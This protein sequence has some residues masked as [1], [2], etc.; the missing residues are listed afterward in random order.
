MN[1]RSTKSRYPRSVR[2]PFCHSLIANSG[3]CPEESNDPSYP[4]VVIVHRCRSHS[5]ANLYK[6]PPRTNIS[7]YCVSSTRK[8]QNNSSV[9]PDK[10]CCF[11][12][13]LIALSSILNVI[14][15]LLPCN[16]DPLILPF[17]NIQRIEPPA[18]I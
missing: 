4:L 3:L 18:Y 10:R 5:P 8:R 17:W 14:P 12:R 16:V 9:G 2:N 11:T 6:P 13:L 15:K 1:Q 7:S